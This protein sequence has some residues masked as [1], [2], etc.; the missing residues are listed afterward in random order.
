MTPLRPASLLVC[1][2]RIQPVLATP[3][4]E[5]VRQAVV[6]SFRGQLRSP[7]R[8]ADRVRFCE[9]I[10]RGLSIDDPAGVAGVSSAVRARRF[11]QAGGTP[12]MSLGPASGRC[13]S[14]TE[15]QRVAVAYAQ[16]AGLRC[17]PEASVR[18][19][20]ISMGQWPLTAD[21]GHTGSVRNDRIEQAS[22]HEFGV[23]IPRGAGLAGS[24]APSAGSDPGCGP[25]E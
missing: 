16:D 10:A 7:R 20:H 22:A 17:C 21:S 24:H 11:R 18:A 25:G 8:R 3:R 5:G 1:I 13:M 12:P 2:G 15:R 23:Q 19:C 9:V 14:L 6:R 4:N